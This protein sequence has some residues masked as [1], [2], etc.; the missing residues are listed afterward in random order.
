MTKKEIIAY[1]KKWLNIDFSGLFDGV[2]F[3][4]ESPEID[5]LKNGFDILQIMS[6]TNNLI[7]NELRKIV[8]YSAIGVLD[9][10]VCR[11]AELKNSIENLSNRLIENAP[12]FT[13]DSPDFEYEN[14]LERAL[15][16]FLILNEKFVEMF[17]ER[18]VENEKRKAETKRL[19][20]ITRKDVIKMSLEEYKKR[21]RK[22]F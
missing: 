16:I 17:F 7:R 6:G 15:F 14:Q 20:K 10:D 9:D 21:D 18:V 19:L 12:N 4:N 13:A 11:S 22:L 5:E 2:D 3:A 1:N 8:Y